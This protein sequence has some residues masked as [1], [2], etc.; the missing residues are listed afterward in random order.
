MALCNAYLQ[1]NISS[2][3][4]AL[5]I[6]NQE[7]NDLSLLKTAARSQLKEFY[8]LAQR[9]VRNAIRNP[10]LAVSQIVVA[11]MV[12]ILIGLIYNQMKPTIDAGVQNRLGAIFFIV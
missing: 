4:A 11:L 10:E 7:E 12:A 6:D 8:Y 2:N 1:S 5:I 9:T 3:N